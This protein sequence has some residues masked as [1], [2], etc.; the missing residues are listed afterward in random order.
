MRRN[1]IRLVW[2]AWCIMSPSVNKL[3]PKRARSFGHPPLGVR[4][5]NPGNI[6]MKVKRDPWQ[7]RTPDYL[8]TQRAYEEFTH[9]VW[10]VRAMMVT[11]ITYQD[12]YGIRTLRAPPNVDPQLG[13]IPRFAPEKDNNDTER[14]IYDVCLWTGFKENQVLNV[15]NFHEAFPLMKAMI[16]K[17]LGVG[18]HKNGL[19]VD[20]E[21]IIEGMRRAGVV[22]PPAKLKDSQTIQTA[23]MAGIGGSV[24]GT[25]AVV[26]YV[27]D[28]AN[29]FKYGFEPGTVIYMIGSLLVIACCVYIGWVK[30][31]Q[32]QIE[33]A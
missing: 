1:L 29:D 24:I 30:Y 31:K 15:H 11:L 4:L 17:E 7:G 25:T 32:L 8:L 26:D 13:I 2:M 10:G 14:Y 22:A 5:N 3:R 20:D 12:K 16:L 18:P 28:A 33:N 23:S 21:T 27:K 19:W 6:R 9:M